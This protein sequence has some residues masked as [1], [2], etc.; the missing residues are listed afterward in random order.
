MSPKILVI[1]DDNALREMVGI[2]LTASGFT[3]E[4]CPDGDQAMDTFRAFA[5]DL[6]LLDVMLPGQDGIAVCKEIR[7]ISGTPIIMLTAKTETQDIVLGLEAGADDYIVKPFEPSVL[8]ARINAR[9]RPIT[10]IEGPVTIGPLILDVAG[11][12]VLRNGSQISLTPLEF[13]LLLTLAQKPK[14]VFT[15]EM[16]LEKVWGYHYKADTRLVNVHV[17]RLRSKIEDDPD[18]PTIVTTVRGIGYRAG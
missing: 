14:Q 9:L 3:P 12:Q 2:V 17:Q 1:D 15:R 6:V 8:T 5:P 4:Y 11:H 10:S 18:N 7:K 13:N 16:L